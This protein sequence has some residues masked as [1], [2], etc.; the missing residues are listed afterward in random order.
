VTRRLEKIDG[1][2]VHRPYW[3]RMVNAV[4]HWF[5][6]DDDKPFLVASKFDMKGK[7]PKFIGY[8]IQRV[9]IID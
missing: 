4:L 6:F 8:T 3:K 5:Q 9:E 1:R 7:E 2:W